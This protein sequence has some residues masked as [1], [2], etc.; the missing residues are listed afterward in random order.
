MEPQGYVVI[1]AAVSRAVCLAIA[2]VGGICCVFL[3]WS[4][5][6]DG[7]R[8]AT[9]GALD[10]KGLKIKLVTSGPG[11]FLA[12]FGAAILVYLIARLA[13]ITMPEPACAIS[14]IEKS[15][16]L[17]IEP[18]PLRHALFNANGADGSM[19]L[20]VASSNRQQQASSAPKACKPCSMKGRT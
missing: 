3:G 8:I 6:R 15:S 14:K 2:G 4:L 7:I 19:Q 10:Y 5:Y 11:V 16:G 1:I 9:S 18:I 20:P 17:S 12:A 13:S